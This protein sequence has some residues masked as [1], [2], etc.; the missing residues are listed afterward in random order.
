MGL[1]LLKILENPIDKAVY[2]MYYKST[3]GKY[4]NKFK[5]GH[6][7]YFLYKNKCSRNDEIRK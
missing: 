1:N 2:K 5:R 4:G 3:G 7:A 6:K